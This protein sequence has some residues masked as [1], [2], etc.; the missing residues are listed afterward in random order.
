[1]KKQFKNKVTSTSFI[2]WYFSDSDDV[3]NLGNRAIESL[4]NNGSFSI[5]AKDLFDECGYIPQHIC[6]KDGDGEYDPKEVE[7]INDNTNTK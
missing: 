5:S 3:E 1:M 4:L 7:F 2:T 6:E